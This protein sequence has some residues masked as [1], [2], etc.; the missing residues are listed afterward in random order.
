M[1]IIKYAIYEII[2]A[3]ILFYNYFYKFSS[4]IYV[5]ISSCTNYQRLKINKILIPYRVI[6]LMC[7]KTTNHIDSLEAGLMLDFIIKRYNK[8]GKSKYIFIHDHVKSWHQKESIYDRLNYLKNKKYISKAK[9]GGLYCFYLKFGSNMPYDIMFNLTYEIDK[10][11]RYNRFN[12]LSM[13]QL[14]THKYIFPCCATFIV[15][16]SRI[17]QHPLMFYVSLRKGLREYVLKT[18]KNKLSANYMEYMWSIIFG[19][20]DIEYPPDCNSSSIIWNGVS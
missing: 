7:N 13:M 14:Y 1:Y 15:D 6:Y 11:M 9:Y 8:R 4:N 10:Y 5:V 19:I 3:F 18:K 20:N 17:L 12:N 2:F 16:Y